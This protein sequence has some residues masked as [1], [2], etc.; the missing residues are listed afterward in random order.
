VTEAAAGKKEPKTSNA[1]EQKKV[2]EPTT[3]VR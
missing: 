2:E 3:T 1:L